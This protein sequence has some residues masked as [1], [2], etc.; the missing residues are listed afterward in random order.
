MFDPNIANPL[1]AA[2]SGVI[3]AVVAVPA[4]T[5]NA[6]SKSI[7]VLKSVYDGALN[8]LRQELEDY[9]MKTIK[10]E[11]EIHSWK[12]KRCDREDCNNRL[13]PKTKK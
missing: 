11:Q 5:K 2:I 12:L 6:N 9:K 1:I 7:E 13:P 10:L 8:T 3:A 4:M